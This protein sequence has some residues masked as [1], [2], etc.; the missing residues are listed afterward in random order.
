MTAV[1]DASALLAFLQGEPGADL[2]EARLAEG[3][4]CGAANW[5]EVAQKVLAAGRD[6]GLARSLLL[7]YDLD[8]EPV[9]IDDAEAAAR[10]WRPKDGLSL[11]DRLCLALAD[12]N[13]LDAWTADAAWGTSG[14]ARQIR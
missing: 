4:V 12:R 13:D 9:T 11:A 8:V 1:I 5:S 6:W 10:R 3:A 7:S 2:V 14:R